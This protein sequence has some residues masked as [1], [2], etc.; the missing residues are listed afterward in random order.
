MDEEGKK[1][2][3]GRG[4]GEEIYEGI[5][6]TPGEMSDI[7]RRRKGGRGQDMRPHLMTEYSEGGESRRPR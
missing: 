5:K 4:S 1:V 2:S 3:G 6:N 7:H